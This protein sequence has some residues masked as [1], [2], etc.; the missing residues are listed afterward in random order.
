MMIDVLMS[1]IAISLLLLLKIQFN[2]YHL[3]K[4]RDELFSIRRELFLMAADNEYG[5]K[6]NSELYK[7]FETLFN[8]M[9]RFAH[10]VSFTQTTIFTFLNRVTFKK[11]VIV[12]HSLIDRIERRL[13]GMK[14]D[15][16]KEAFKRLY[17][18]YNSALVCY[19]FWTSIPFMIFLILR[20][21]P[22]I[23]KTLV[24]AVAHNKRIIEEKFMADL[25]FL[26]GPKISRQAEYAVA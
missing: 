15:K 5:L 12:K 18:K 11:G 1:L 16:K 22:I 24:E 14:G 6:F 17:F 20:S 7:D 19:L 2:R 21:I 10:N 13:D 8:N 26:I 25:D 4:L 3:E 9:I 23:I